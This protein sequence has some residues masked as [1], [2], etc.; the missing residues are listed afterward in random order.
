MV[1]PPRG[2][3]ALIGGE[4]RPPFTREPRIR[5]AVPGYAMAT[6]AQDRYYLPGRTKEDL[7]QMASSATSKGWYRTFCIQQSM[8]KR[9]KISIAIS[10][11]SLKLMGCFRRTLL[12]S[13]RRPFRSTLHS[14]QIGVGTPSCIC[15]TFK[16]ESRTRKGQNC[17]LN[18]SLNGRTEKHRV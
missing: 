5:C 18:T 13:C 9:A 2:L 3:R 6:P 14:G 4:A 10:N 1:K 15:T 11:S 8:D 17:C 16:S 7:F 12:A